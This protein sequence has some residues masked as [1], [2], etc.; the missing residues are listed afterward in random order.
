MTVILLLKQ[1][2]KKL[3]HLHIPFGE[4]RLCYTVCIAIYSIYC[5]LPILID[6]NGVN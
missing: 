4:M 1:L 2:K 6:M 5:I 3:I